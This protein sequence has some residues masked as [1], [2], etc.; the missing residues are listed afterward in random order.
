MKISPTQETKKLKQ[1]KYAVA[2][3][4]FIVLYT[5]IRNFDADTV[6]QAQWFLS[7]IFLLCQADYMICKLRLELLD[8]ISD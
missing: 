3:L 7:F 8:K 6:T 5:A 4:G 1:K 2:A